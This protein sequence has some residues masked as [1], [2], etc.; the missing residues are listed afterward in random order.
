MPF[1]KTFKIC[2]IGPDGTGKSSIIKCYNQDQKDYL[3][4]EN[5]S[6]QAPYSITKLYNVDDK[7]ILLNIWDFPGK[8]DNK[9][10]IPLYIRETNG[11]ILIFDLTNK[12]SIKNLEKWVKALKSFGY[13]LDT[14][15]VMFLLAGNKSDLDYSLKDKDLEKLVNKIQKIL[16]YH[17]EIPFFEVSAKTKE[18]IE[19]LFNAMLK[20]LINNR[21]L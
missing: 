15:T 7:K 17:Y 14:N 16:N 19:E 18:N 1:D 6:S 11:I 4:T 5:F 3:K 20:L 8:F 21:K 10:V 9:N 12:K 2:L 13:Y